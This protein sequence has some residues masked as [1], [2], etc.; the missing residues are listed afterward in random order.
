MPTADE[1]IYAA[2]SRSLQDK[3]NNISTLPPSALKQV[4]SELEL[5]DISAETRDFLA[6]FA[7]G[8][9]LLAG[10]LKKLSASE[11]QQLHQA[12]DTLYQK[13]YPPG[14]GQIELPQLKAESMELLDFEAGTEEEDNEDFE[15]LD[16]GSEEKAFDEVQRD[17]LWQLAQLL[18]AHYFVYHVGQQG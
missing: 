9:H 18:A 14:E 4:A 5:P 1:E 3:L 7:R 11:I 6:V 12:V 8:E 2:A 16:F 15:L 13:L 10:A 17:A